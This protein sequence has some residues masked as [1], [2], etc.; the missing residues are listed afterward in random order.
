M[1]SHLPHGP[2]AGHRPQMK[3]ASGGWTRLGRRPVGPRFSTDRHPD[4][5]SVNKADSSCRIRLR[6][7]QCFCQ[8]IDQTR[9]YDGARHR[10]E[11]VSLLAGNVQASKI[12]M[13]GPNPG[14]RGEQ[15]RSGDGSGRS[16]DGLQPAA[17]RGSTRI[18]APVYR[19]LQPGG[20]LSVIHSC[21][22][23][24]IPCGPTLAIRPKPDQC[25]VW[26][27][28]AGLTLSCL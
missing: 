27:A 23:I 20:I 14:F 6:L 28:E 1:P 18:V 9:E 12:S 11:M 17:H 4:Q 19:T 5:L 22:D 13:S 3:D 24:E 25:A 15:H 2:G 26:I 21:S 10:S 16:C 7:R 8:Q